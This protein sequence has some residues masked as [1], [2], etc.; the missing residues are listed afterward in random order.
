[1]L[2]TLRGDEVR[3][4]ESLLP[5]HG[6][7]RNGRISDLFQPDPVSQLRTSPPTC[8]PTSNSRPADPLSPPPHS[9]STLMT[10]CKGTYTAFSGFQSLAP[11][12]S[13]TSTGP[14]PLS[15]Q[16]YATPNYCIPSL[17]D[18]SFCHERGSCLFH[19]PCTPDNLALVVDAAQVTTSLHS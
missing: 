13:T 5:L 2:R 15:A 17:Y 10:T 19:Y 3:N 6:T 16:V 11:S 9:C 7:G 18:P 14:T 8:P 12:T 1:M 4:A